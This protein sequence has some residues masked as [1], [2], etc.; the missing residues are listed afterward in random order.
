MQKT[1][2]I[3]SLIEKYETIIV[4]RHENPDP[5]ALGSKVD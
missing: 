5:D 1:T 4:H 3:L 2:Q